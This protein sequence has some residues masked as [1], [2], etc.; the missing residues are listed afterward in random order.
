MILFFFIELQHNGPDGARFNTHATLTCEE[1]N[2]I[3]ICYAIQCFA[4]SDLVAMEKNTR[5]PQNSC[6]QFKKSLFCLMPCSMVESRE[7][8]SLI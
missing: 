5:C 1:N 6:L 2:E 4:V 8:C 3:K 7:N